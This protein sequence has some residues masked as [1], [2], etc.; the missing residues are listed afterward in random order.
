MI[1]K[2][3]LRMLM[4]FVLTNV[5]ASCIRERVD[6]ADANIFR[7]NEP[8]GIA[9]LD[10]ALASYQ[11]AIWATGHLYNGLVELDSTL[12]IAPCLASSWQVSADGKQ[13]T[14]HL[15]KDVWFHT[16]TCFEAAGFVRGT[17]TVNAHDVVFSLKRV[18]DGSTKSTGAWVYRDRVTKIVAIDSSTVQITLASPF[19]PFLAVLTMPYGYIVPHEAT[20]F[21]AEDY[22]RHPV[23]TG[24]FQFAKWTSDVALE[25]Q[26]NALYFKHDAAGKQLPYLDGVR[27]SFLRDTKSE[28]LEFLHDGYD[29][30]T[31][32]DGAFAPS[33]YNVSGKLLEPYTKYQIFRAPALS[34]E[35]YGILLDTNLPAGKTSPLSRNRYLRQA[36][37]L[38]IDRHRIVTYV[39]HG[40]GIP[41]RHGMLPPSLPG[42]SELVGG[43]GFNPDSAR[44]LLAKA[45]YPNGKGL[46]AI[47]LQLGHNPRTAS[48]AEAIQEQ[49]KDIGVNVNLRMVDFPQHL[50]QV[51]AGELAMWRTSWIG[52]Y[53]DPENFLALFI[54]ANRSPAGPNTTHI[55]NSKLDSLY[56]LALN[57]SLT[58][59][60][61]N[62]MYMQMQN[63]VVEQ[64]PWIFL[65]HDVLIRLAQPTISG[66][67]L[68]GT[69]RLL[70]ETVRKSWK[71]TR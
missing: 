27:I 23:G 45:G 33:V 8:D 58:T 31:S 18:Y 46:P 37:N 56:T 17:R 50:S 71:Q 12:A 1:L 26:R 47:L 49:W 68:D 60:Q 64:C 55:S 38:A 59:S 2:S 15:R 65:Y 10:P 16:D 14:F 3:L 32:V 29:L 43:Y 28:F 41:T 11:S 7:Y 52:D 63:E 25:M 67:S 44:L 42:Y 69:G 61:R 48:V 53:P 13:Y 34:V 35:Y 21:Y 70:L 9:S 4:M 40:R 66:M 19:A 5:L 57:P 54:T 51:R 39:L 24:P 36:L 62:E 22:G 30:V 6:E 20:T